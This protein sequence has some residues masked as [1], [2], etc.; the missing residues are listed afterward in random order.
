MR[1]YLGRISGPLLDRIDICAEA[2]EVGYESLISDRSNESSKTIRKRVEEAAAIQ[3]ER[4]RGT[5]IRFNADLG[6]RD[7]ER[8]CH[9]GRKEELLMQKAFESMGLSA[10]AY[11]RLIRVARTIADLDGALDIGVEHL[12]EAI[13]FR[14]VDRRYWNG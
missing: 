9:L 12:S 3:H 8:Y 7:L 4:Y 5:D 2:D 14:S 11:H 10:R 6:V 13:G 1:K